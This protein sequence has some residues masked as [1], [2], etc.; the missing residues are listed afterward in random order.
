MPIE[1]VLVLVVCLAAL[2][3]LLGLGD[4]RAHGSQLGRDV[5]L[6]TGFGGGGPIL[7]VV[8]LHLEGLELCRLV[9]LQL[10]HDLC[11]LCLLYTSPSPRD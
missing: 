2:N 4:L 9:G 8:D 11:A 10:G 7:H 1:P 6:H 3:L 5:G